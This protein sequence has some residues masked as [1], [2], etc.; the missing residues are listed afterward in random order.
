MVECLFNFPRI[1]LRYN[2]YFA[3]CFRLCAIIF[4]CLLMASCGG[5]DP[6]D[7]IDDFLQ[8]PDTE[9]IRTTIKTS[10]PLAHIAAVAMEAASGNPSSEVIPPTTTC[11]SYPCVSEVF[12]K[13]DQN[14]LPFTFDTSGSVAV[15]G[16]WTSPG[17]AILTVVFVDVYAGV[18]TFSVSQISTFPI[19][20]SGN[21]GGGYTLVFS[22]IDINI[23]S[24][25]EPDELSVE[26]RQA[27]FD[28]LNA[29][30]SDD[31]EVNMSLDAWVVEVS[32]AGTPNAYTDDSYS[33]SGGGEYIG[34]ASTST[35]SSA[36]VMQLGLVRL[37]MSHDCSLNPTEGLAFINEVAVST[38]NQ[39][40]LPV[41]ASALMEFDPTCD[42]TVQVMVATGNYIASIGDSIPINLNQ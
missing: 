29:E 24:D 8:T 33:I 39:G 14:S 32:D 1:A 20:K 19:V 40:S 41:V 35:S 31:A 2:G 21:P 34:V 3:G 13:L 10:V 16:L 17:S 26:E 5:D 18:P 28:R 38:G 11:G 12:M 4:S 6:R 25:S 27:E 22:D 23:E 9:P 7:V 42:G 30:T 37:L 36:N 15:F